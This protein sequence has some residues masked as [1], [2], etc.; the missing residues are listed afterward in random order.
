MCV[1]TKTQSFRTNAAT[2]HNARLPGYYKGVFYVFDDYVPE[3]YT[4]K[5]ATGEGT[6]AQ[7]PTAGKPNIVTGGGECVVGLN[8]KIYFIGGK[9]TRK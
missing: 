9:L 5:L 8:D 6:W 3:T 1:E 7:M 2:Y 4:P